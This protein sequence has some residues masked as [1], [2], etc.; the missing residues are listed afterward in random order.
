[1][2]RMKVVIIGGGFGGLYAAKSMGKLPVDVTLLDRRNYHLF[3]PLLYQVATGGLS[4]GDIASPIRAVLKKCSNVKTYYE[5]A[6]DIDPETRRVKTRQRDFPYDVLVLAT[7]SNNN[8]F[9]N[10]SWEKYAPGLKS[11]ED[12]TD[13]RRRI[14]RAF[15]LAEK[16]ADP[17]R[18]KELLRIAVI[19]GGPTGVEICGAIAELAKSTL[20]GNFRI[21]EPSEARI[22][23]VEG[24]ERILQQFPEDLSRKAVRSLEK[25]GVEVRTGTMVN[26][27]SEGRIVFKSDD[28]SEEMAAGVIVWAAGVKVNKLGKTFAEKVGAETDRSG[29]IIVERDL[30]IPS[31]PEIF[32]IGDLAH[33]AHQTGQPLQGLAPV[34]M[35][36]GHYVAKVLNAR[37][38][39]RKVKPFRYFNKGS[40]AVIGRNSAVA[41]FGK[42]RFSGFL[43]WLIWIFVHIAYLIEYD[44]K[45][46]VMFQWAWDYF[47]RK[48]GARLITW[49][50]EVVADHMRGL[51]NG[52]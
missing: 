23:L 33:Y 41:D 13:I 45:L 19:G 28:N 7:G 17:A 42:L 6:I 8:Y 38:K 26:E 30:T 49:E 22:I 51:T 29:K 52:D 4:P 36:E 14:L 46:L 25:L 11:I 34:A 20:K 5:E 15:E 43:A 18:R 32:I 10:D 47:T 21:I 12:A 50:D 9:G 1:M 39:N 3:Q 40:L 24:S 2:D 27:I 48:R 44:N 35:Q 31:H 37:I 16:E